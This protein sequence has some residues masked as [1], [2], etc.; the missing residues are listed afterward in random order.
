MINQPN[1][2]TTASQQALEGLRRLRDGLKQLNV[3]LVNADRLDQLDDL[4][5]L[6]RTTRD[7]E[8]VIERITSHDSKTSSRSHIHAV[9]D[10][11]VDTD[12]YPKYVRRGNSLVKIALRRN[13][14]DTYEMN[15]SLREFERVRDV[16]LPL[17]EMGASFTPQEITDQT[18]YPAYRTYLVLGLL[19]DRDML[20]T[21][22]R[23]KYKFEHPLTAE[24]FDALWSSLPQE[25]S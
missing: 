9:P 5:D 19:T 8:Q 4:N 18:A 2:T 15:M 1:S 24:D 13:K 20:S 11:A 12:A 17:A 3:E 25:R 14:K 22:T 16:L 10:K 23:G 6:L 21:P 7:M